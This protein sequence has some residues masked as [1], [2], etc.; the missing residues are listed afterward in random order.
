MHR[1]NTQSCSIETAKQSPLVR[2]F[3]IVH[4]HDTFPIGEPRNGRHNVPLYV[5]KIVRNVDGT[6][7]ILV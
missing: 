3:G 4:S 7:S 1:Y 5:F 2:T 6:K